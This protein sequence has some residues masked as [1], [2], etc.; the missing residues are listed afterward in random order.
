MLL[1]QL[2]ALLAPKTQTQRKAAQRLQDANVI[3]A[4]RVATVNRVKLVLPARIRRQE[5]QTPV[6]RVK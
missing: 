6:H 3:Q 2:R 1:L 4:S 5:A